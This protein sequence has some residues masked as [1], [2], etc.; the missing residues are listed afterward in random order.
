MSTASPAASAGRTAWARNLAAPIRGFLHAETGGALVLV[1]AA[2]AAIAWANVSES[3]YVE[4]WETKLSLSL[5]GHELS[6][7]LREWINSGLMTLFFLVVGLEAKRELDLGELRERSRLAVPVLCSLGGMVAAG[8][9]YL[10]INAGGDGAHGW[11]AAV[12]TDTALALGVLTLM[13]RG[14]GIRMRVFLLTMVVIDDLVALLIIAIA[15]T[16]KVSLVPLLIA[17][18]LF[19]VLIAL[20]WA[21]SWRG[22][23]A[24]LV[25]IGIWLAMFES[26]V[27][28]IIAGLAIGLITSA[29]PPGRDDLER[30]TELARSFRE[31]PTPE[32]AYSAS[33]SLTSAISA[34]ER[35]QYRLHP[36]TSRVIVPLFALANAGIHLDGR[37][38]SDAVTSPITWGIVVAFLAGKPLGIMVAAWIGSRRALGGAPL[39]ITWPAIFGVGAS[40][41]IGFTVSLLVATLAFDGQLLEEAKIG[42]IATAVISPALVWV[43]IQIMTRLPDEVRARQLGSTAD[44]IVDLSEDV[45]PGR[46]HIRGNVDAPVTLV[47]YGDYECPYC[48]DAAPTIRALHERLGDDMRYVF[49]HLPLTD[50]HPN[51]QMASEAAECAGAQGSFWEMHDRLMTPGTG[52]GIADLYRHANEIGLD[53]ERFSDDLRRRRFGP[54]VAEDVQSADA[55]GV[56]GTPTFFVNGRRHYGVYDVETLTRAIKSA[57]RAA[58]RTSA[59]AAP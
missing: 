53:L 20:R 10:A 11:G 3:S 41:G 14:R 57:A 51:A 15:Y 37:L 43:A 45:E 34:N 16:E 21:G 6:A 54:R 56:S 28:A 58:A 5:G 55:S 1:A 4:V 48:A 29:Y 12:S 38:I 36:W 27:D 9:V 13:T 18:G 35:M 49:R 24:V 17:I 25:G 32:L 26:G 46:D 44:A 31:Q 30:S 39:T 52:L 42:V 2:F 40:A 22:P 23:V 8:A 47:E 33:A 19:G 7:D 59:A 50:V